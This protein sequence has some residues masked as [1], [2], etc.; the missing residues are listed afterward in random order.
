M[1]GHAAVGSKIT[2]EIDGDLES[3][4]EWW[5]TQRQLT[6]AHAV[7]A[8]WPVIKY[9]IYSCQCPP[10]QFVAGN[11]SALIHVLGDTFVMKLGRS[12][13]SGVVRLPSKP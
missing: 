5:D 10:S 11:L 12:D 7:A 8:S 2:G 6:A 3:I 13:H 4:L 9:K 1:V